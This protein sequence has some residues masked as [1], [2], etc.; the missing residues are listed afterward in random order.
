MLRRTAY[1]ARRLVALLITHGPSADSV[2]PT[3][4]SA[5]TAMTAVCWGASWA[6]SRRAAPLKFLGFCG[7]IDPANMNGP[8]LGCDEVELE[9]DRSEEHTSELQSR[10]HLVCRLL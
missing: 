4:A 1:S 9:V 2:T 8:R 10:L 3:A 7:G 5:T 6:I